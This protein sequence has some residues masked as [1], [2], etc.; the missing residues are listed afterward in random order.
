MKNFF[1]NNSAEVLMP[2]KEGSQG[3]LNLRGI[4][5]RAPVQGKMGLQKVIFL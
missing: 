1:T 3:L 5:G 2:F 4:L